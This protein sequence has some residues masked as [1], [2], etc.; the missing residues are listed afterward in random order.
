LLV[1]F[2]QRS[3]ELEL[4]DRDDHSFEA[5]KQNMQELDVI[6]SW[7]GGHKITLCGIQ[8]FLST[9]KAQGSVLICEV[10]CGGGDNLRAVM[11]W[12]KKNSIKAEFIG[13]DLNP[14]CVNYAR[15][16]PENA[17][18]QFICS[19]YSKVTFTKK[20]DVIFSSLFT[21]HF[22]DE[23]I[24]EIFKWMGANSNYGFFINDLHRHPIAYY[25]IKFATQ[26]FSKSSLVKN[27][28]PLSV[29]RGFISGELRDLLT[30][31]S[32]KSYMLKWKW[33][34]RWLIIA[35]S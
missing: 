26:L 13:I 9:I 19:D 3:Y 2:T 11:N 17:G 29:R 27:D 14:N 4:L 24:L 8:F 15:S 20:P 25:F 5:I 30:K 32:V 28:A 33:A 18:I 1:D 10:G 16:R 7:L 22:R 34:F 35:R 23:A 21:H 31:A 12:C 6:N